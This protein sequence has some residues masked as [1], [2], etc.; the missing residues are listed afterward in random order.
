[1]FY[2]QDDDNP[3]QPPHFTR[4][5]LAN[6]KPRVPFYDFANDENPTDKVGVS[7]NYMYLRYGIPASTYEVGDETDRHAVQRAAAVFADE[8]MKLM[9][10]PYLF[11]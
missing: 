11:E 9:L 6:A 10:Q 2:T 1:V 3:T 8:L 5:W 4:T 7:K